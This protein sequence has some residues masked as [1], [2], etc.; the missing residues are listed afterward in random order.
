M[1]RRNRKYYLVNI[2]SYSHNKCIKELKGIKT[3]KIHN[4]YD[5]DKDKNWGYV[6]CLVG[7]SNKAENSIITILNSKWEYGYK[8]KYKEIT[9]EMIGH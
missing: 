5:F 4:P 9:K 8:A 2:P 1:D 7:F 3:V 6:N